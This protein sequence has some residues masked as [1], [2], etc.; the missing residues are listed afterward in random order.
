MRLALIVGFL[1]VGFLVLFAYAAWNVFGF[2]ET[3]EYENY[4][5][6]AADNVF[7]GG[8]LPDFIPQSAT[9]LVVNND[10]DVNI[11]RGEFRYD[12]ADTDAFVAWLHP[13][14]GGDAPFN[15]Y[16]ARVAAMERGGYRA[17][18]FA[19][20]GNVWVFFVNAVSGRVEYDMWRS[21]A[22]ARP[23]PS[24]T[25]RGTEPGNLQ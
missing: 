8:W 13:W 17:W 20:G 22:R 11:S 12:P 6:A 24:P 4:Q 10:Y 14:E 9:R 1:A 2:E 7:A 25:R 3:R 19:A 16:A 23:G 5:A 18:E 15:D 21:P